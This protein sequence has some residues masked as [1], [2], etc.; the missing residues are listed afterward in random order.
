MRLSLL[1]MEVRHR[2]L[3][4]LRC[5]LSDAGAWLT[6]GRRQGG[7][8][9][10]PAD[11]GDSFARLVDTVQVKESPKVAAGDA[12]HAPHR[13]GRKAAPRAVGERAL[14]TQPTEPQQANISQPGFRAPSR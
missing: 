4:K 7:E 11:S 8:P 10:R 6:D 5:S 3:R 1:G 13:Q 12:T 2:D 9:A 14:R